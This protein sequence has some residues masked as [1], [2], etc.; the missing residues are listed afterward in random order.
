MWILHT[1]IK[2]DIQN[3][4]QNINFYDNSPKILKIKVK[5]DFIMLVYTELMGKA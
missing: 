4:R 3:G 5:K 2:D 1:E